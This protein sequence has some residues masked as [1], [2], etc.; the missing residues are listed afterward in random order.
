MWMIEVGVWSI[1]FQDIGL[2]S[3]YLQKRVKVTPGVEDSPKCRVTT[4]E[5]VKEEL[6][7][8]SKFHHD[9]MPI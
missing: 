3:E 8:N 1:Y 6:L 4:P 2:G 7:Y 9:T 5:F